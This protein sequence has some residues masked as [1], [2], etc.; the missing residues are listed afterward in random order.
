MYEN[1]VVFGTNDT[2]FMFCLSEEKA[3]ESKEVGIHSK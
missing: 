1:L 2:K 3:E